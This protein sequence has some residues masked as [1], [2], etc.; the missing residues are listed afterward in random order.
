ML[1]KFSVRGDTPHFEETR[2]VSWRNGRWDKPSRVR[3]LLPNAAEGWGGASL[4]GGRLWKNR[5][6][7]I[8]SKLLAENTIV[9]LVRENVGRIGWQCRAFEVIDLH[10]PMGYCSLLRILMTLGCFENRCFCLFRRCRHL[11]NNGE[12]WWIRLVKKQ[13]YQRDREMG[14]PWRKSRQKNKWLSWLA[15]MHSGI[16][17]ITRLENHQ[18]IWQW[19]F[20]FQSWGTERFKRTPAPWR[21]WSVYQGEASGRVN[22]V[23][24]QFLAI[25]F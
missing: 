13:R 10:V 18:R 24:F 17:Q 14:S 6:C 23:G 20:G 11:S 5:V 3:G 4:Q 1:G 16:K 8:N 22:K 2:I 19:T 15:E 12:L 7:L 21:N 25:E 9:D